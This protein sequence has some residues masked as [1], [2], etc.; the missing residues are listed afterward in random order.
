MNIDVKTEVRRYLIDKTYRQIS[1]KD[2]QGFLEWV[3]NNVPIY[4]A[5]VGDFIN[6]DAIKEMSADSNFQ[7]E[8]NLKTGNKFYLEGAIESDMP[9]KLVDSEGNKIVTTPVNYIKIE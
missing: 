2:K 1:H 4:C 7:T 3:S 8:Y 5:E 6:P 9:L